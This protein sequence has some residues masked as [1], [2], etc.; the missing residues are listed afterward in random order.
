MKYKPFSKGIFRHELGLQTLDLSQWLEVDEN[1]QE[2]TTLKTRLL[3]EERDK[4]FQALPGALDASHEVAEMIST[5]LKQHFPDK[6][7]TFDFSY[8][9]EHPLAAAAQWV[10]EDLCLMKTGDNE[11]RLEAGC[12][13]FP[14]RWKLI[15]KVGKN[16]VG[17]HQPVPGFN[18]NLE[19]PSTRFLLN[20]QVD[21][22]MWRINW[23]IHDSDHLFAYGA[24]EEKKRYTPGTVLQN[25]FFRSE[26]Q[27]LRRLPKTG[28]VLFTIRTYVTP[29][30]EV[31]E[32]AEDRKNLL[33]SLKTMPQEVVAYK[34]MQ[35]LWSP[36]V[37]ALQ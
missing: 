5:H 8:A 2:Q 36:L 31:A 7:Q 22:P 35:N 20:T 28:F 30:T 12:V 37:E 6:F 34:G 11:A 21:R 13:C 3:T 10:Q 27:T 26:R 1:W 9:E 24:D 29:M 32:N 17:I 23:T 4:V 33:S 18:K 15:E 19:R 16:M 25:T 14:S